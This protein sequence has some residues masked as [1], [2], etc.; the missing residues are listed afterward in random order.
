M[1]IRRILMAEK[2]HL[3]RGPYEYEYNQYKPPCIFQVHICFL[4]SS[5]SISVQLNSSPTAYNM[6]SEDA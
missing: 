3:N 6:T 2:I 5:C 4:L 1:Q